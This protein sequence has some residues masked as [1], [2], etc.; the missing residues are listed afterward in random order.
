MVLDKVKPVSKQRISTDKAL[1]NG[2]RQYARLCL[3]VHCSSKPFVKDA[4]DCLE[5]IYHKRK[6]SKIISKIC[7]I[8]H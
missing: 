4:D 7:F 5:Y 6:M 1:F 2:L 3:L 8:I